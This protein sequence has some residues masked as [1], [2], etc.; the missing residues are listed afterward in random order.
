MTGLALVAV[1]LYQVSLIGAL[2]R[3]GVVVGEDGDQGF[4]AGA[5]TRV[6]SGAMR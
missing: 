6:D 4:A 2:Q 1:G 3:I 5:L